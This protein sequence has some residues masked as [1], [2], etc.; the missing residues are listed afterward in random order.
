[1][2]A[3]LP[4]ATLQEYCVAETAINTKLT[5]ERL[6]LEADG[7]VAVPTAPGLGIELD[8]DV[9]TSLRVEAR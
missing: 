4:D 2:N 9:F 3:V 7:C 5:R 8:E 6:P 1:V